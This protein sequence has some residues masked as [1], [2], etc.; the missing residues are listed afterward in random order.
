MIRM[1]NRSGLGA[2]AGALAALLLLGSCGGPESADAPSATALG[3]TGTTVP[4]GTDTDRDPTLDLPTLTGEADTPLVAAADPS[5]V[6]LPTTSIPGSGTTLTIP[7]SNPVSTSDP[8]PASTIAGSPTSTSQQ[9]T[10]TLVQPAPGPSAF[11]TSMVAVRGGEVILLIDTTNGASSTLVEF[12]L[13]VDAE[14]QIGPQFPFSV[15]VDPYNSV[16]AYDTCCAEEASQ[17]HLYDLANRVGLSTTSGAVPSIG[18]HGTMLATSDV[19]SLVIE[20]IASGHRSVL[21]RAGSDWFLGR[22]AWNSDGSVLAAETQAPGFTGPS[23]ALIGAQSQ[24]LEE[25]TLLSPPNGKA[26]TLPSF[27]HDDALVVVE[28]SLDGSAQTRLV[29]IDEFGTVIDAIGLTG[30]TSVLHVDHD[31]SGQW[32]L[33][34]DGEG[35]AFW[36]GPDGAGR[37]P[38]SGYNAASW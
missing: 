7:T 37:L 14:N 11:P 13:L 35:D 8:A 19:T 20:D 33:V 27:R 26:W 22:T 24:S 30:L 6:P 23:I 2:L 4:D 29:V 16:L 1:R 36:F 18:R 10:T 31:V 21:K 17:T 5:D 12:S 38:G 15:D 9:P 32:L 25:A 28:T 34:V 3:A